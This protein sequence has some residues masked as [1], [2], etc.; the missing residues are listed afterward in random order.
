MSRGELAS[1]IDFAM[2][3]RPGRGKMFGVLVV[4]C[5][6]GRVGYLSGF[7]GMLGERWHVEGFAPPLFNLAARD[8]FWPSVEAELRALE[9]RHS[10]LSDGAEVQSVRARLIELTARHGA[11]RAQL[12]AHHDQKRRDRQDLRRRLE[13]GAIADVEKRAALHAL[14][15]QSREDEQERRRIAADYRRE[16]GQ[17]TSELQAWSAR[18]KE[19]EQHRTERSRQVWKQ[20]AES[21][22]VP[23]AR[24]EVTTVGQLYA[25]AP[26]PGGAGDCAAPKLLAHAFRQGLRPLAL[27]EFWL[28]APPLTEGRIAREFYP[29][30]QRRCGV[31]LPF[32][33]E[34]LEVEC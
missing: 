12:Q 19:L 7:S 9:L 31:V 13:E 20:I 23:N 28:G 21:Y 14:A 16:R 11:S 22:V 5:L 26:P 24:G 15:Y 32:M 27:A 10:E 3:D 34:G 33:L 1:G 18:R 6:D 8:A 4:A 25:P 17:L 2:L 29:A 30:C